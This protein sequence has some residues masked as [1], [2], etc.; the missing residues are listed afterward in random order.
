MRFQ[1]VGGLFSFWHF[2][3]LRGWDSELG[4]LA[5]RSEQCT[6]RT[7]SQDQLPVHGTGLGVSATWLLCSWLTSW[8]K[9]SVVAGFKTDTLVNMSTAGKVSTSLYYKV[10]LLQL[11]SACLNAVSLQGH[12][13]SWWY[14]TDESLGG[15]WCRRA[16]LTCRPL[17]SPVKQF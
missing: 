11:S 15:S 13:K 3:W 5:K 4:G 2:D 17:Y 8:H 10:S 6:C 12:S 1:E 9:E 7:T 16:A 14:S